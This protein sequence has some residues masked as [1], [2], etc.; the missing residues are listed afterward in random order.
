MELYQIQSNF[1]SHTTFYL[2]NN[3]FQLSWYEALGGGLIRLLTIFSDNISRLRLTLSFNAHLINIICFP[4]FLPIHFWLQIFLF[5]RL[6]CSLILQIFLLSLRLHHFEI[7]DFLQSQLGN[8]FSWYPFAFIGLGKIADKFRINFMPLYFCRII[9]LAYESFWPYTYNSLD[10]R[11]CL[12]Y[13]SLKNCRRWCNQNW[14]PRLD[15]WC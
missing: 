6:I 12:W 14:I 4:L 15:V 8:W 9:T 13:E 10:E 3:L 11:W 7:Q 2:F 1:S 5:L